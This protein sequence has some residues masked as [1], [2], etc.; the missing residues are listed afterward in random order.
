MYQQPEVDEMVLPAYPFMLETVS[1][2][3]SSSLNEDEPAHATKR[4]T[5]PF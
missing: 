1:K 2:G 4:R 5:P 3:D